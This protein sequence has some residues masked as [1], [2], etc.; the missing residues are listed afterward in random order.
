MAI[1]FVEN[2]WIE[3]TVKGS[4][5][6]LLVREPNALEGARYLATLNKHS[7]ALQAEDV[8]AFEATIAAHVGLLTACVLE[9]A[10]ITPAF[11]A[12]GTESDRRGWITRFPFTDVSKIA[13]QVIGVGYPKNEVT[14]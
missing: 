5:G 8:E 1:E 12:N 6:R 3:I 10:D 9:S 4:T 7:S 11:P 14:A 2:T 13:N